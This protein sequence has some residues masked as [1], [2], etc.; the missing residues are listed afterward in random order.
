MIRVIVMRLVKYSGVWFCCLPRMIICLNAIPAT[1]LC[2]DPWS[3]AVWLEITEM[4]SFRPLYFRFQSADEWTDSGFDSGLLRSTMKP[5]PLRRVL[6][7][8]EQGSNLVCL[9]HP[10][11]IVAL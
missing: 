2:S 4:T 9:K 5:D 7:I 6:H 1:V 3:S 11:P 10:F 8:S